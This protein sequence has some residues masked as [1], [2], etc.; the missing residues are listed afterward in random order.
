MG[1]FRIRKKNNLLNFAMQEEIINIC[2]QRLGYQLS[3]DLKEQIRQHKW[4]CM[5][6]EMIIDTVK[7]I[8]ISQI[9]A[10]LSKLE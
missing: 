9:E 2:F 5:G 10:Y 1:F 3:N 4:S 8:E 7:S 6:L